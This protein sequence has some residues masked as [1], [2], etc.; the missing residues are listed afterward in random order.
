LV[1]VVSSCKYSKLLRHAK[2]KAD[3][4][5]K[6]HAVS[7]RTLRTRNFL[8]RFRK[9]GQPAQADIFLLTGPKLALIMMHTLT[10]SWQ[11]SSKHN[12]YSQD[13]F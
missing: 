3:V 1:L 12:S 10:G 5:F 4:F 9:S 7:P 13:I 11:F 6:K 2:G 8:I